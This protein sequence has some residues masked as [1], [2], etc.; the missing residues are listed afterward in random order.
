MASSITASDRGR[1]TLWVA[2][3]VCVVAPLYFLPATR[4]SFPVGFA[5]LYALMAQEVGAN[6]FALPLHIPYYGPGGIPFAYPPLGAYLMAAVD[7]LAG[8]PAFT[9]MRYAPPLFSLLA[10]ILAYLFFRRITQSDAA[11]FVTVALIGLSPTVFG[12][13]VTAGGVVRALA[14]LLT[15]GCLYALLRWLQDHPT[16]FPV[17]PGLLLGLTIL[18]HLTNALFLVLAVPLICFFQV[19]PRKAV[20]ACARIFIVGLVVSAA[21]W[22]HVFAS[23]GP[24]VFLDAIRSHGTTDVLTRLT[25]P[26]QIAYAIDSMRSMYGPMPL[27]F[28]L[29]AL[30]FGAAVARRK[31][32][33]PLWLLLCVVALN[34]AERLTILVG[35]LLAADLLAAV[36]LRLQKHRRAMAPASLAIAVLVAYSAANPVRN[37]IQTAPGISQATVELSQWFHQNTPD[38]ATFIALGPPPQSEW[39]PYLLRRTPLIG[40]WGSEW[41]GTYDTAA[42]ITDE[43]ETCYSRQDQ[44]CVERLLVQWGLEPDYIIVFNPPGPSSLQAEM[45]AHY[46]VV[47]QNSAAVVF[48]HSGAG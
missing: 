27:L 15:M 43:A 24:S 21:W 12:Y 37:I 48:L 25:H 17:W 9:Y 20:V 19:S 5:G 7:G 18:T 44:Q 16:S 10:L 26:L 23:F 46:P 42:R 36:F 30:G 8:L 29:V 39:M 11:S 34:E 32:F 1:T 33:L 47:F 2:A 40:V 14:Q 45:A 22:I 41:L 28:I 4:Y 38:H 6:G 35:A 3:L 13:N 31:W